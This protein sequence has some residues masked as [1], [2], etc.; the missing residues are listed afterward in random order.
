MPPG[1]TDVNG[2]RRLRPREMTAYMVRAVGEG[3]KK[4]VSNRQEH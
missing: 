3:V 2:G 4:L 1:K